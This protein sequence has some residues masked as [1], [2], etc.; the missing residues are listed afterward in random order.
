MTLFSLPFTSL[1]LC[2]LAIKSVPRINPR[3]NITASPPYGVRWQ[4]AA[5][6]VLSMLTKR[7]RAAPAIALHSRVAL[8]RRAQFGLWM[9]NALLL[10][11][12]VVLWQK[13]QW[14]KVSDTANGIVWQRGN[15]THTDR[16]RDGVV[17]EEIISLPSGEKAIRRDADLDGWFDL[18][19]VERRGM[20]TRL[21]QIHEAAPR[22]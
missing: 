13:L 7:R 15:T 22:H 18:R 17:D 19:Y 4:G 3:L 6:A 5:V 14:E 8:S 9:F 11:A 1:R 20:A 16:N 21:E 2:A 10:V 12:A